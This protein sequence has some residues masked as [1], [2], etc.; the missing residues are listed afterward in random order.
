[1]DFVS[2]TSRY[3]ASDHKWV[4]AAGTQGSDQ[5][6]GLGTVVGIIPSWSGYP[7]GLSALGS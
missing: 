4:V 6:K 5:L 2:E 3:R 1:M 7:T